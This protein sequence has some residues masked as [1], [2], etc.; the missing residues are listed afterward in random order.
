LVGIELYDGAIIDSEISRELIPQID[1]LPITLAK[2]NAQFVLGQAGT[3][4]KGTIPDGS[5]SID[6][7]VLY[8]EFLSFG[9]APMAPRYQPTAV[10][11]LQSGMTIVGTDVPKLPRFY[12]HSRLPSWK[13]IDVDASGN[14]PHHHCRIV[15]DP[16]NSDFL[17]FYDSLQEAS[18]LSPLDIDGSWFDMEIKKVGAASCASCLSIKVDENDES[19]MVELSAQG[20]SYSPSNTIAAFIELNLYFSEGDHRI[21]DRL[22]REVQM[23]VKALEEYRPQA[24]AKIREIGKGLKQKWAA[25]SKEKTK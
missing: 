11:M 3:E 6:A 14:G 18:N 5:A 22:E 17:K 10:F 12:G 15:V 7:N 9:V 13:P 19:E 24:E 20:P 23:R 21:D 4:A 25:N 16:E 8:Q 1:L 2:C